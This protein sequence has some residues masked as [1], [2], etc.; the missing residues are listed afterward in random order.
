MTTPAP[1]KIGDPAPDFTLVDETG[2]KVQLS[3]LRGQNVL[4]VFYPL[5]FSPTCT[6]ELQ[7]IAAHKDKYAAL[8]ARV[9]GISVDSKWTHAAFKRDESLSATLLADFHPK[10]AVAQQYG[11][12]MDGAGIAK[13]GTFVIDKDGIVRGITI[14][15]PK[16]AR[17]EAAYFETLAHCPV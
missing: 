8:K 3:T 2:A 15:E 12:Y 4:L 6:K 5:D 14:N 1:L 13:R 10:G 9:F 11:V 7:S 16:D 17:D